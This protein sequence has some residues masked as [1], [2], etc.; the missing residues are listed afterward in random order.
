MAVL[1]GSAFG[2]A[3]GVRGPT[4]RLGV[5]AVP[6]RGLAAVEIVVNAVRSGVSS[7]DVWAPLLVAPTVAATALARHAG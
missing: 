4:V 1:V 7:M 2:F 3:V 5:V 6:L